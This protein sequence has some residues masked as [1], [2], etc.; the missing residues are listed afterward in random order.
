MI[1]V[2]L[3]VGSRIPC[4]YVVKQH[5]L[6]EYMYWAFS[7]HM[8]IKALFFHLIQ[9]QSVFFQTHH[10]SPEVQLA[11]AT[12]IMALAANG[13]I[14]KYKNALY[15]FGLHIY[16]RCKVYVTC[17]ISLRCPN[18]CTCIIKREL[19]IIQECFALMYSVI[20]KLCNKVTYRRA[21]HILIYRKKVSKFGKLKL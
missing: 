11:G 21:I 18:L 17:T 2:L 19:W 5:S 16:R 20:N 3:S 7:D 1:Q 8:L 10:D 14:S 4:V 9:V 6:F 13:K 12:L 15:L